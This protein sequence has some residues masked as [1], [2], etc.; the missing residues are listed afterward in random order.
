M[1]EKFQD[2]CEG[3]DLSSPCT[4]AEFYARAAAFAAGDEV[5]IN[6]LCERGIGPDW[7]E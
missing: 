4:A 5:L 7:R 2:W 1:Y 6:A 3:D